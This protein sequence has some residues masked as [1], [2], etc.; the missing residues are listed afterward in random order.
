MDGRHGMSEMRCVQASWGGGGKGIRKAGSDED[1]QL[2]YKQVRTCMDI[3][4]AVGFRSVIK[5]TQCS[6]S[7]SSKHALSIHA[8]ATRSV[9]HNSTARY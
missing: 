6:G 5:S 8:A 1:V 2:L 9:A 3:A 4:C 7:L